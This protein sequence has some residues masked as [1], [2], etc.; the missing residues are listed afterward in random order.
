M[1]KAVKGLEEDA[2]GRLDH[3]GLGGEIHE[4]LGLEKGYGKSGKGARGCQEGGLILTY[5]QQKSEA[6]PAGVK[7]GQ[8]RPHLSLCL[9]GQ[10]CLLKQRD[11]SFI[12]RDFA[13]GMEPWLRH[14]QQGLA[15]QMRSAPR[16]LKNQ[17][18]KD[19]PS[20]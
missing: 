10:P 7:K 19:L 14:S 8:G 6:V 18:N 12:L 5:L 2:R 13:Q 15:T 9:L 16:T 3:E 4:G 1:Q 17:K 11:L 20:T